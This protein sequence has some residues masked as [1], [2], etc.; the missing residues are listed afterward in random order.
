MWTAGAE[1]LFPGRDLG[2]IKELGL[3]L[4]F[5]GHPLISDSH[6]LA[7][8]GN[9]KIRIH[10]SA[11]GN[12]PAVFSVKGLDPDLFGLFGGN[13]FDIFLQKGEDLLNEKNPVGQ[14]QIFLD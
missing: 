10:L 12:V 1:S 13:D 7:Q 3:F 11:H 14:R 9:D 4:I 6:D 5:F 2:Q 8:G